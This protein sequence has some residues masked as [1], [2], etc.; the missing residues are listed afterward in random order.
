MTMPEFVPGIEDT[1]PGLNL[2]DLMTSIPGSKQRID[3]PNLSKVVLS[4]AERLGAHHYHMVLLLVVSRTGIFEKPDAKTK[5]ATESRRLNLLEV[6]Y[7]CYPCTK[8][9]L[10]C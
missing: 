10:E 7:V 6:S 2:E 5:A 9:H 3:Q 8:K 4:R 1:R